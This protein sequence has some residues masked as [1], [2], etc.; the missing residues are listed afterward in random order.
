MPSLDFTT[1]VAVSDPKAFS[2]EF[3]KFS[4]SILGTPEVFVSTNI[5]RN[6]LL[7]FNGSFDPAFLMT[8]IS[9]N[10]TPEKNELYSKAFFAFFEEKLGIPGDRGY[11]TFIDPGA[12][13]QGFKGTTFATIFSKK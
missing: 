10:L 4:A 9:L 13:S 11:I 6:E 2:L 7:T 8:I 3:S 5:T 12:A 1:N